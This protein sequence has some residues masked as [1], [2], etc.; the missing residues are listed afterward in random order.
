MSHL[1]PIPQFDTQTDKRHQAPIFTATAEDDREE[2]RRFN[3]EP[4]KPLHWWY[5]TQSG[6]WH[7]IPDR[8]LLQID[9]FGRMVRVNTDELDHRGSQ[10]ALGQAGSQPHQPSGGGARG[11]GRERNLSVA[12]YWIA[13]TEDERES[14][15]DDH[16]VSFKAFVRPPEVPIPLEGE[17]TANG[18]PS[19]NVEVS[20]SRARQPNTADEILWVV[21]RNSA[22]ELAFNP[23]QDFMDALFSNPRIE[24]AAN[25]EKK[26][27]SD[28]LDLHCKTF[29]FSSI[30]AYRVLKIATELFVTTRCGVLRPPALR[31]DPVE[32]EARFGHR[33][34]AVFATLWE[35]YLE[36]LGNFD[37]R[38]ARILPY[39]DLIRRKLGDIGA[40][41]SSTAS[42]VDQQAELIQDKL[43]HPILL[44][45]IWS[46]WMEEGMLVQSFNS[47]TRRFQNL[48][49][50]GERDP[51]AQMEIDPLRPVNNLL[52]GYVQDE[53]GQPQRAAPGARVRP[54]LRVHAARQGAGRAAHGR[55]AGRSSSRR[56]TTCCTGACSSTQRDDDTTV[57]A[58]AFPVLNALKETH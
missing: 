13:V 25:L 11:N 31:P 47:I 23:Y 36:P 49:T 5:R 28:A 35:D 42:L 8:A 37:G 53:Q 22:N 50:N 34:G 1:K 12:E 7:P 30:D 27:V 40:V 26:S 17:G 43:V 10:F 24:R 54:P 57:I 55:H 29:A 21:I 14:P 44:E 56:S 6:G 3:Y 15:N 39:L 58:D 51:L 19:S 9:K 16:A 18:Q 52:W 4:H 2:N 46:Y 38:T 32:E 20:L 33:L 45:L 41:R 48:R